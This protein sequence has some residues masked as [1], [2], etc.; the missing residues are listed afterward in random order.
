MASMD[1]DEI[2]YKSK[3]QI[4]EEMLALQDIGRVLIEL[5]DSVYKT[6]PIPDDLDEAIKTYRRINSH[7]ARKRQMQ[8]IGRVIRGLDPKPLLD[9]IE[10]HQQGNRKKNLVFQALEK[11]RERIVAGEQSA[12]DEVFERYPNCERQKLMQLVRAAKKEAQ[13]NQEQEASNNKST[14]HFKKLFSFLKE[15]EN[16]KG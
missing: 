10:N 9:A 3:T 16:T 12:V 2:E 13:K 6:F 8:Y 14:K 4:K 5:P 15:L 11:L 7:N 1:N